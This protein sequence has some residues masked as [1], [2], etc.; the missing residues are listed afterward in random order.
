MLYMQ[1]YKMILE[2]H[3]PKQEEQQIKKYYHLGQMH[4]IKEKHHKQLLLQLQQLQFK[5]YKVCLIYLNLD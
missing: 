2:L 1:K 5:D 4:Q 3:G